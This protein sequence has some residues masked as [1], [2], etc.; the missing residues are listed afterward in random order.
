MRQTKIQVDIDVYRHLES[1]RLTFSESHNEILRRIL[2]FGDIPR[3]ETMPSQ[4]RKQGLVARG[5][6]IPNGLRLRK[7]FK[8][9][10]IEAEVKDDAIEYDGHSYTSP[11]KPACVATGTSVNGWKFWEYFDETSA[12]W[13]PL[14]ALRSSTQHQ[15]SAPLPGSNK[16]TQE[17]HTREQ[18]DTDMKWLEVV[19]E[20]LRRLN[21][22]AELR[23]IYREIARF[24]ARSLTRQFEATVRKTIES[25]S[26]DSENFK[27]EDIFYSVEGKGKGIWGLREMRDL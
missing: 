23:E 15:S 14:E 11:S 27:G 8:G 2:G 1:N 9:R 6:L 21:G 26:S 4:Q 5:I 13:Q 25:H 3:E 18:G 22:S 24:S 12:S 17:L 19:V 10:L 20:A 16:S 7:V